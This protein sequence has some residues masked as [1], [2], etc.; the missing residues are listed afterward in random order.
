MADHDHSYKQLFSHPELIRDL[1]QGFI[2][3]DWGQDLDLGTLKRING[4]YVSDDLREREDDA[5]WRVRLG[6]SWVYVYLLIEFQSTDQYM[7][8][9]L[10]TFVGLLYQDLQ[11]TGQLLHDGML[12]PVL[13]ISTLQWTKPMER[14]TQHQFHDP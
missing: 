14:S 3:E 1:L 2:R 9:R 8:V 5:I 10:L 12:P 11:K 4:S 7:A 13:S 6:G